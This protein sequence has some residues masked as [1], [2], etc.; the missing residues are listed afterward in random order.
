MASRRIAQVSTALAAI[1]CG[2]MISATR[3]GASAGGRPRCK[4]SVSN[5]SASSSRNSRRMSF[6]V[7]ALA[8]PDINQPNV[9]AW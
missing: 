2:M 7:T 5:G 8:R 4:P 9:S 3:V 6:P 1:S